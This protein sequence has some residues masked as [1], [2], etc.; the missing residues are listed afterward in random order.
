[1]YFSLKKRK[2]RKKKRRR[3]KGVSLGWTAVLACSKPWV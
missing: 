3:R 1:M 2:R